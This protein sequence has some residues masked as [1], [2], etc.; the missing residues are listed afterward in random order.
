MPAT[1]TSFAPMQ[2]HWLVLCHDPAVSGQ[3]A[4]R[5][6]IFEFRCAGRESRLGSE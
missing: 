6:R 1:T 2:Q 5:E 3:V 4:A